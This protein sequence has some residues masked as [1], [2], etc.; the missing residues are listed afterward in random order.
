[1]IRPMQNG[2]LAPSAS[3]FNTL[4]EFFPV[5]Q[6]VVSGTQRTHKALKGV[7]RNLPV[8]AQASLGAR[9][10]ASFRYLRLGILRDRF[11]LVAIDGS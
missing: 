6:L 3:H 1:M 2:I 4:C 5:A 10:F 11:T 7:R 9:I 8:S